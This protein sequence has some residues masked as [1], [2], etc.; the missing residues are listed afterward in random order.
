MKGVII[1]EQLESEIV[2]EVVRQ[3]SSE[4]ILFFV[5]LL[6]AL[7]L[8]VLPLYVLI[9]RERKEKSKLENERLINNEKAENDRLDKFIQ[10]ENQ[11]M[12]V[13]KENSDVI[14]GLRVAL[15]STGITTA[16]SVERIHERIDR[17]TTELS[18]IKTNDALVYESQSK[19]LQEL[20]EIR[21]IVDSI[22]TTSLFQYKKNGGQL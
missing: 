9:T 11:I 2:N 3:T 10:R 14:A 17:F 16:K 13:I 7:V 8:V 12:Q 4:L 20:Q 6:I 1:V 19:I 5:I 21:L 15:E 18:T 22:P